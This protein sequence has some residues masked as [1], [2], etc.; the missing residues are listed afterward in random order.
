MNN[1]IF[2]HSDISINGDCVWIILVFNIQK[3][4]KIKIYEIKLTIYIPSKYFNLSEGKKKSNVIFY[5]HVNVRRYDFISST[6][7]YVRN[8]ILN[9]NTK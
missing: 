4:Q 6:K 9:S 7:P 3:E 2:S 1:A 5:F 8:N